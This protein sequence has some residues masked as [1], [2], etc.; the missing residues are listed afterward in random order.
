M[1]EAPRIFANSL[2]G[3][4][5]LLACGLPGV[6]LAERGLLFSCST[7][8]TLLHTA[9]PPATQAVA[10]AAQQG[11]EAIAPQRTGGSAAEQAKALAERFGLRIASGP[12]SPEE[13]RRVGGSPTSAHLS[14]NAY[15][16]SGSSEQMMNLARWAGNQQS[17]GEVFYDPWGQWDNGQYKRQGIGGHSDHVHIT[18]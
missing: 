13:N 5:P 7:V 6:A 8:Q 4:R 15:D 18:F 9:K 1:N 17:Y 2:H 16:F 12:R 3:A 11:G 10:G 14:G